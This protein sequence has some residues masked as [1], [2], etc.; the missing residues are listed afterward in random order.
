MNRLVFDRLYKAFNGDVL[1]F[2]F[3]R[4]AGRYLPEYRQVR[5]QAGG[6]LTLC[7][8]PEFANEVTLQPIHRFDMSA[9]ILFSD[10]LVIP[11]GL[12]QDLWFAE[13]EGPRLQPLRSQADFDTLKEPQDMIKNLAPVYVAL[14]EV[15]ANLAPEKA[16]IGFTGAPWT[17]ALYMIEGGGDQNF[18]QARCFAAREPELF[19]KLISKLIEAIVLHLCHQVEAG[20]GVVQIFDSWAS[21]TDDEGF[22]KWVLEPIREIITRFRNVHHDVPVIVFPR[23]AGVNYETCARELGADVLSLDSS[24]PLDWAHDRL[25]PHVGLQGSLDPM[26]L[27]AGGDAMRGRARQIVSKLGRDG[28]FIFNLGHGIVPATPPEHVHDLSQLLKSI[29]ETHV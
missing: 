1:P 23:G 29:A 7:Y 5:S 11:H 25:K 20:A 4:Q 15:R 9:A 18:F 28:G 3:M 13:G 26:L 10:I 6:F 16:L 12:G 19:K 22:F 24:V 14:K 8:T 27:V 17:L 2:W 21:L